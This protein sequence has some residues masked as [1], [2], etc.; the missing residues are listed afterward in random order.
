M[1]LVG[2]IAWMDGLAVF[3]LLASVGLPIYMLATVWG[4]VRRQR[5][6]QHRADA[7]P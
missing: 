3:L 2:P 1:Y 7:R 4:F 5:D 6:I